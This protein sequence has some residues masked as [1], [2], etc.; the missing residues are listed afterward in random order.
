M[1]SRL[2]VFDNADEPELLVDWLPH[3]PRG[4]AL[5]T[6]R[7]AV[8][9]AVGIVQPIALDVLNEDEAVTL[10]VQRT[11]RDERTGAAALNQELDGLPLAL[12]QAGAYIKQQHI[13]FESYLKLY[14]RLGLTQLEKAKANTGNYPSTVLKTWKLNFEA[15]AETSPAAA[16]LLQLSAF[17][18]PDDIPYWIVI[19]GVKHLGDTLA[20]QLEQEDYELASVAMAEL[21]APLNQYSLVRWDAERYCYSVHRL[22]QTVIRD[23]LS[24]ETQSVW[25]KQVTNLLN[26]VLPDVE[27]FETLPIYY[28]QVLPHGLSVIALNYTVGDLSEALAVLSTKI[29]SHLCQQGKYEQAEPI[30]VNT[31]TLT[32]HLYGDEHA[33]VETSLNNLGMVYLH[34]GKYEQAEPI[35]VNAL[36]LTKHLYGDEDAGVAGSLNNLAGLYEE[37]EQYSKAKPLLLEALKIYQGCFGNLD[38][39]V[40]NI[41]NNLARIYEEQGEY[42]EAQK[43]YENAFSI[44]Q[45][46]LGNKNPYVGLSLNNLAMVH[47]K[48]GQYEEAEFCLTQSLLIWK[49]IFSDDHPYLA[50]NYQNLATVYEKQERYCLFA[51]LRQNDVHFGTPHIKK[52]DQGLLRQVIKA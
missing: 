26:E 47:E 29:A 16:K 30:F 48:Q 27:K 18:A 38:S 49:K 19:A 52:R 51:W 14:E 1:I 22:V 11:G 15:V 8:F 23:E 21:L 3:N 39:H 33:G 10:L 43:Y 9:D 45:V 20:E 4:K 50:L 17:F 12:E 40:A 41:L 32:K 28:A 46:L 7:A 24:S 35:F 13:G 31:F 6:S 34:Q 5:L 2:L 42:K 37:Q 25:L 36:T 44:W